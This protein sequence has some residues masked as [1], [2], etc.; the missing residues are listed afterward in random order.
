MPHPPRR[1]NPWLQTRPRVHAGFLKSWRANGLNQRILEHIRDLVEEKHM[2]IGLVKV[3]ITGDLSVPGPMTCCI[4]SYRGVHDQLFHKE[5][6]SGAVFT[7]LCELLVMLPGPVYLSSA[8]FPNPTQ[9][10]RWAG[11][12]PYWPHMISSKHLASATCGCT[13]MALLVLATIGLLA[14]TMTPC[15]ILGLSST[16]RRVSRLSNIKVS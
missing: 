2:D 13:P 12:W 16:T 15:L 8:L 14:S 9:D 5:L 11:R 10:I 7:S 6:D 4:V 1:G 3:F